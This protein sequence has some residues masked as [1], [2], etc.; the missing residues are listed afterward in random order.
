LNLCRCNYREKPVE[1]TSQTGRDVGV[2]ETQVV[3]TREVVDDIALSMALATC[4]GAKAWR[5]TG[6]QSG[7]QEVP[8]REAG[9]KSV[10]VR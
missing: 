10:A 5:E 1:S 6:S 7:E 4:D 3:N 9:R 2:G 8:A